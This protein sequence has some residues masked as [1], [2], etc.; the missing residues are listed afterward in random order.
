MAGRV[1][2]VPLCSVHRHIMMMVMMMMMM[3]MMMLIMMIGTAS[4]AGCGR[5][6]PLCPPLQCTQTHHDDGNDD[7]D[8]DDDDDNDDRYSICSWLWR[9]ASSVSPSAVYIDTS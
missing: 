6:R 2:C 4:V 3:M 5:M 8:D 7:D 9:D 1:L